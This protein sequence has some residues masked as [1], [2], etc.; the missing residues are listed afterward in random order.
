MAKAS[1]KELGF[2]CLF[3][4]G[5]GTYWYKVSRGFATALNESLSSLEKLIDDLSEKDFV[6]VEQKAKINIMY[7]V[8]NSL[9]E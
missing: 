9:Y 1:S 6:T 8:L 5:R 2:V 3:T 4:D 7:R